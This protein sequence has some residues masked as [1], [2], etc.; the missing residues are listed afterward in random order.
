MKILTIGDIHGRTTWK[1]FADIPN[2]LSANELSAG[3][4][5]FIPQYD[6][7]V[8]VG[9]YTDSFDVSNEE[10]K[11]NLLHIIRFK[12]LYPEH[13]ILLWGNHDIYYYLNQPWLPVKTWCSGF[14]PDMHYDL[15]E[16]F[17]ESYKHFR[18]AFQVD[19]YL[20][21]HAGV[22][23]G[24]YNH[25]F[26]PKF[27]ELDKFGNEFENL[28]DELNFAFDRRLECIFD[29]DPL[30][31]GT[32]TKVG[33]PLWVH[34]TQILHKPLRRFQQI[35]GHNPNRHITTVIMK[36]RSITLCDV[37]EHEDKFHE[38]II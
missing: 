19:K 31:G 30:R 12:R 35:A 17:N 6:K 7:Y 5:L 24:W 14:R 4:D 3:K 33:G 28:A 26:L 20:W 18:L 23:E 1:T 10:I 21:T 36:D 32:G 2:L 11:N 22:H 16:I 13:V 34:K 27:N 29:I 25:R 37:L 15:Y 8:F 38:L 9:D